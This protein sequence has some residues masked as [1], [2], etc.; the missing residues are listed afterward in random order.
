MTNGVALVV[1]RKPRCGDGGRGRHP[2]VPFDAH[3][4]RA[5]AAPRGLSLG[6]HAREYAP[7]VV[8]WLSVSVLLRCT[9]THSIIKSA[10]AFCMYI[11]RKN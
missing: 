7:P 5:A 8:T 3:V 10:K 9:S 2:G 4:A 11:Q 6:G 1:A